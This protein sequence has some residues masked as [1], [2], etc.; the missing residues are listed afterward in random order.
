MFA[1]VLSDLDSLGKD[2]M[3]GKLI[4]F[5]VYKMQK[6]GLIGGVIGELLII[7]STMED[8]KTSEAEDQFT[9]FKSIEVTQEAVK[10][11]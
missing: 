10:K 6:V 8:L 3:T 4:K 1:Q 2:G 9:A 7:L 5:Q 11:K